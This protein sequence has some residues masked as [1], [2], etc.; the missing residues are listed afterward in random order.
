MEESNG[1][2]IQLWVRKYYKDIKDK[3][4]S[5]ALFGYVDSDEDFS[6]YFDTTES[7]PS[8]VG[9]HYEFLLRGKMCQ[10]WK[11]RSNILV[12]NGD[13]GSGKTTALRCALNSL[14]MEVKYLFEYVCV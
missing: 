1:Q 4:K 6:E 10:S 3:M 13:A 5:Q 11:G 2:Y 8:I 9:K 12:I 14:R 7:D